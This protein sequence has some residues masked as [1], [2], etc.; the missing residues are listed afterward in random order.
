MQCSSQRKSTCPSSQTFR[1]NL[2]PGKSWLSC[3]AF[4]LF[5]LRSHWGSESWRELC[6]CGRNSAP[7]S[8]DDLT[9]TL[10]LRHSKLPLT[11][12]SCIF[13]S[14]WRLW[15]VKVKGAQE[16]GQSWVWQHSGQASVREGPGF[17]R[18]S[19]SALLCER[20]LELKTGHQIRENRY[21]DL[22]QL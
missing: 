4:S 2:W 5:P 6:V 20:D 17:A 9:F 11:S 3:R 18:V 14:W 19:L 22:A 8:S 21:V 1:L 7:I 13:K 12:T 10:P 16:W 15:K